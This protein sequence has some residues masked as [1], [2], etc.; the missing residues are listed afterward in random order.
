MLTGPV[1]YTWVLAIGLRE[2]KSVKEFEEE[3]LI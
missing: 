2:I 1:T 3:E